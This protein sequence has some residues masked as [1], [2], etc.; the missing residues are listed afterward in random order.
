MFDR[1][2]AIGSIIFLFILIGV[3]IFFFQP[4]EVTSDLNPVICSSDSGQ[5]EIILPPPK[6]SSTFPIEQAIEQ[7]RSERSF[8]NEQLTLAEVS[9]LLWAGQGI[10]NSTYG[11]RSAP[12]AGALYPIE[13]YLVP[14]RVKGAG[15]GIYHY[16]PK[17]HKLVLV[18]E[19]NFSAE[20]EKA[21]YGQTYVGEA[22][23]VIIFTSIPA[24]TSIKYGEDGAERFINIEAGHISQNVLL[25]AVALDLG[26]APIGGFSQDFVDSIL[27]IDGY[28]EKSVYM[29]IVGKKKK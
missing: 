9:Q 27:G 28:K 21:S 5:S 8:S 6:K 20:M 29:T 2:V 24:R 15:C 4:S 22:A 3:Y 18:K 13:L 7:R 11:F 1:E 10:T 17:D 12:S 19:G 23:A 26:A 14:N 16:V 25:Q